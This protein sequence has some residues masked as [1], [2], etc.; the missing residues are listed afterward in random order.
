MNKC[1]ACVCILAESSTACAYVHRI[2]SK[3]NTKRRQL[4]FFTFDSGGDSC[5]HLFI[6]EGALKKGEGRSE[7][8]LRLDRLAAEPL[9][10]PVSSREKFCLSVQAD[11]FSSS[12]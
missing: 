10:E 6:W 4:I 11:L 7:K 8:T 3:Q 1:Y 5:K 12:R 2:F 9:Q